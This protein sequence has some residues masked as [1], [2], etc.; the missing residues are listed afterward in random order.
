M[1]KK[2]YELEK[3]LEELRHKNRLEEIE[4]ERKAKLEVEKAKFDYQ[5]SIHRLKRA[6]IKRTIH[7]KA[8][9]LDKKDN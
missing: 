1:N 9:L 6:D 4:A 7:E 8:Y 2:E 3:E 5:L